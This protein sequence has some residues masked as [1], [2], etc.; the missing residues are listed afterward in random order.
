MPNDT[1]ET[2]CNGQCVIDPDTGLCEGC[3]RTMDEIVG[4]TKYTPDRRREIMEALEGRRLYPPE[5]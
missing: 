2:P 4:W 3:L 1:I 5:G